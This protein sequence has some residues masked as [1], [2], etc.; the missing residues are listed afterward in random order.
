MKCTYCE[1]AE[2]QRNRIYADDDLIVSIKEVGLVPGHVVVFP[3]KHYTILE[4]IPEGVWQKCAVLANKVG[5]AIFES[6][7]A[8]GTNL[9]VHNGLGAQQTIPHVALEVIPRQADD[10]LPLQ[11]QGKQMSEEDL[12]VTLAKLQE[13]EMPEE[14]VP[15]MEEPTSERAEKTEHI[16]EDAENYLLKSL[17]RRP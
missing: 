7:G 13:T 11:W 16:S 4:Q 6:L 5:R 15:E 3:R 12:A 1:E 10:G 17:R 9:L 8:Q 2:V 14:P